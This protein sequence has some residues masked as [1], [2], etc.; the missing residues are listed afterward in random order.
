MPDITGPRL[1]PLNMAEPVLIVQGKTNERNL[2]FAHTERE[3]TSA[4][5]SIKNP[6]RIKRLKRSSMRKQKDWISDSIP[7]KLI[8]LNFQVLIKVQPM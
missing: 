8:F 4:E 3:E 1:I 7:M 2:G 6:W 5:A